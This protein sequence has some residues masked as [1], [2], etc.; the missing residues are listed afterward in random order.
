M[1]GKQD[2]RRE[3]EEQEKQEEDNRREKIREANGGMG[4]SVV[5]TKKSQK[6][7]ERKRLVG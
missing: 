6:W 3:E 5:G 7:R 4:V 1:K 2:R